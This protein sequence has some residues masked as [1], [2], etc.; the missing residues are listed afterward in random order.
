MVQ[1]NPVS[2]QCPQFAFRDVLLILAKETNII[3][4]SSLSYSLS[5]LAFLIQMCL[6]ANFYYTKIWKLFLRKSQTKPALPP[7]P[8]DLLF[9]C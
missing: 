9:P 2:I 4:I 3:N 5:S 1:I 6:Y 8:S 7:I